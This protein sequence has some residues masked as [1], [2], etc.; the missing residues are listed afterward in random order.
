MLYD[1]LHAWFLIQSRLITLLPSLIARRRVRPQ[2]LW[3]KGLLENQFWVML[4]GTW[5]SIFGRAH[6][7]LTVGFLFAPA[8][9]L[10][11]AVESSSLFHLCKYLIYLCSRRCSTNELGSLHAD[12][13]NYVSKPRRVL[14]KIDLSPP[15]PPSRAPYPH[16]PPPPPPPQWN[17]FH[18]PFQGGSFV[19]VYFLL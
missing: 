4:V 3:C 5:C 8:F 6:R 2:I 18:W 12:W 19:M 1:R 11:H 14:C 15:P 10:F 7:S 16:A 13:T 9:Q 17:T